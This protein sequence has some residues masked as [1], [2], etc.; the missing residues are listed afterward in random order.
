MMEQ[1]P[2]QTPAQRT[3]PAQVRMRKQVYMTPEM[4]AVAR[5]SSAKF[6]VLQ[7]RFHDKFPIRTCV[8]TKKSSTNAQFL[9]VELAHLKPHKD[10]R[11]NDDMNRWAW[12]MGRLYRG[13]FHIDCRLNLMPLNVYVHRLLDAHLVT[14][15]L[16]DD[17][18]DSV[19]K[20]LIA[21]SSAKTVTEKRQ[22]I[23]TDLDREMPKEGWPVTLVATV[24]CDRT[25]AIL[26]HDL[27]KEGN[28]SRTAEKHK[29]YKFPFSIPFRTS[30]SPVFILA[31]MHEE[32]ETCSVDDMQWYEKNWGAERWKQFDIGA[33]LINYIEIAN[34]PDDFKKRAGRKTRSSGRGETELGSPEHISYDYKSGE[35]VTDKTSAEYYSDLEE[36]GELSDNEPSG[37]FPVHPTSPSLLRQQTRFRREFASSHGTLSSQERS[38]L[39]HD[40]DADDEMDRGPVFP[41]PEA[42]PKSSSADNGINSSSSETAPIESSESSSEYVDDE[43]GSERGT[44]NSP[45]RLRSHQSSR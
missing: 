45:I 22:R 10:T 43:T 4:Q 23:L 15:V 26:V 1:T 11:N 32:R 25:E 8:V 14:F 3:I 41:R 21:N 28:Q 20:K 31:N 40:S 44:R 2:I 37:V 7:H 5:D 18:I 19:R 29:V 33:A 42:S 9:I 35:Y 17:I 30:T 27:K 38:T 24:R 6:R 16:D 34:V 39:R 13:T 12:M 36:E